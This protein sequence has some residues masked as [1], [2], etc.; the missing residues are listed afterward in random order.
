[1]SVRAGR[2]VAGAAGAFRRVGGTLA[3]VRAGAGT[4]A[5]ADGRVVGGVARGWGVRRRGRGRLGG[6]A[7]A[8]GPRLRGR[9][10]RF[11]GIRA[12]IGAR[13]GAGLGGRDAGFARLLGGF[14]GDPIL[15]RG[16]AGG[17][18]GVL[19]RLD[20]RAGGVERGDGQ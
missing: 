12:G 17:T 5:A 4:G 18:G 2:L 11:T 13:L 3:R 1:G 8:G 16:V 6:R 19:V 9:A 15:F 20:G 7:G 10:L 14:L